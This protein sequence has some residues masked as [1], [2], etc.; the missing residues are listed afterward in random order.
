M[1]ALVAAAVLLGLSLGPAACSSDDDPRP[2][3]ATL[4]TT[5]SEPSDGSADGPSTAPSTEPTTT[6]QPSVEEEVKAAYLEAA[7][8]LDEAFATS[9]PDLPGLAETR[10]D[11]ELASIRKTLAGRRSQGL[12]LRYPDQ[13]PPVQVVRRVDLLG[14]EAARLIVC[15]VD[16][17]V[18]VEE[19]TGEVVDDAV[20]TRINDVVMIQSGG[21]WKVQ[22]VAQVSKNDS[23]D[24]C[25]P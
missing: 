17:S 2:P 18:A 10:A 3:T 20:V 12:I 9:D 11:P 4:D 14:N 5:T 15:I 16:N 23:A 6:T 7:E 24:G 19:A 13:V 21:T 22:A 25:A 1:A 8:V